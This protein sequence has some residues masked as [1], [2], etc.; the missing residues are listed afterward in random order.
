M[1][2]QLFSV[3][4]QDSYEAIF[5]DR[6]STFTNNP[7]EQS[8]VEFFTTQASYTHTLS[9]TM[10]ACQANSPD[11]HALFDSTSLNLT[12]EKKESQLIFTHVCNGTIRSM[13]N[14][15][16]IYERIQATAKFIFTKKSDSDP[17][18]LETP[19]IKIDPID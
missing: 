12:V 4:K 2:P 6:L 16:K 1:P 5:I 15:K 8:L 9:F 19:S 13:T 18:Q 17:Y 14:D 7:I 10:N 11:K 3:L